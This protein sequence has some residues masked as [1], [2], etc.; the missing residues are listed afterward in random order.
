MNIFYFWYKEYLE[1][2]EINEF[3]HKHVFH[4]DIILHPSNGHTPSIRIFQF[5][6]ESYQLTVSLVILLAALIITILRR[7]PIGAIEGYGWDS[8]LFTIRNRQS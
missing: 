6:Q 3:I 1:G 4:L 7:L 8:K 2:M 5:L